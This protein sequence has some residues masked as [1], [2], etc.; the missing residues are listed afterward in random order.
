MASFNPDGSIQTEDGRTI[1]ADDPVTVGEFAELSK[2]LGP[3]GG[4]GGWPFVSGGGGGGNGNGLTPA[5]VGNGAQGAQG[6]QGAQGPGVGAQGAQGSTGPQGV[7]GSNGAQ[8]A[9]GQTGSGAQGAQGSQGSGG[10]GAQ[11]AQGTTGAQG[12]TGTGAQG[13]QG[14]SGAQGSDGAQGA[15]GSQGAQGATG[16]GA[17]GAQGSSGA[18]GATGAQGA[19]GSSS[20]GSGNV[21]Y[22]FTFSGT[23]STVQNDL[24]PIQAKAQAVMV[25]RFDVYLQ[26]APTGQDVIVEFYSGV[27]LIGTVTVPATTTTGTLSIT[28]VAIP[29]FTQVSV[30]ITQVGSV[31]IGETA[32][33]YARV[34]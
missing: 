6:S 10:T 1:F 5:A 21:D 15:T 25:D 18:Q 13:S 2:L 33:M 22:L 32:S 7:Q 31:T 14:S 17:Q 11:G 23:L 26:Q 20:G 30:L 4:A 16:S 12:A 28:P 27:T 19:Q 34:T 29:A 8:G 24:I 3:K 9:Q